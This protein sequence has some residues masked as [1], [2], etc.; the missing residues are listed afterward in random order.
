MLQTTVAVEPLDAPLG[1]RV[2]GVDAGAAPDPEL[3]ATLR[4]A[5][6]EHGVLVLR[7]QDLVDEDRQVAFSAAFGETSVPWL[8]LTEVDTFSRRSELPGRPYYTGVHPGC[9]YWVNGPGYWDNADDGLLQEWHSDLSY[10]QTPL[11]FSLLYALEA[12]DDGY[13]TWYRDQYAVYD[14]L[15]EATRRR[16]DDLVIPHTFQQSFP[17]L[18]PALHPVALVHP[19]S[20]RRCIYGIPGFADDLPIGVSEEEG[21]ELMAK[22]T[23]DIE[24]ET[25]IYKHAWRKGDLLIWDNRCVTHRRGPQQQGQTRILRRTQAADGDAA[26]LR[27]QLLGGG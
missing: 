27:R 3:I 16:V 5:V 6:T 24:A 11:P 26:E 9:H 13:Q 17:G 12:P 8:H 22:L 2:T 23:A 19:V 21:R 25:H 1:A 14:G 7:D 15:D 4:Q 20:G 18:S 10:L